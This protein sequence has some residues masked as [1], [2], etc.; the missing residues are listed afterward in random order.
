MISISE[1]AQ[2][3]IVEKLNEH[4]PRAEN[5]RDGVN[6][7]CVRLGIIPEDMREQYVGFRYLFCEDAA[8]EGDLKY[9]FPKFSVL[10]HR[11]HIEEVNGMQI[12]WRVDGIHERFDFTNPSVEGVCTCGIEHSF[13]NVKTLNIQKPEPIDFEALF[14]K[15]ED[16][17]IVSE[18]EGT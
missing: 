9:D 8:V 4:L 14:G 3:K 17:D 15:V 13:D 2:E 11:E 10:I 7:P 16:E 6:V 1:I 18:S 5:N 12:D